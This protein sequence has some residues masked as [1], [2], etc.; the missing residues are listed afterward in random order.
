MGPW[1]V[2]R[3]FIQLS[4]SWLLVLAGP[5]PALSHFSAPNRNQ[6]L[7]RRWGVGRPPGPFPRLPT[8]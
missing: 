3:H 1:F 4:H 2:I 8:G 5:L 7:W 6:M